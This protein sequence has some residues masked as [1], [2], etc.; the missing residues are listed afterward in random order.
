VRVNGQSDV[1]V[2]NRR[3]VEAGIPVYGL[4]VAQPSLEDIFLSLTGN[5]QLLTVT[6]KLAD[7]PL[8]KGFERC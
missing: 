1:A 8:S 7:T 6:G 2:I 5:Q 4:H 3:L